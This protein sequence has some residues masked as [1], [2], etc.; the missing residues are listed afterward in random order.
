M[1][2]NA[3]D[4]LQRRP[5][6][7]TILSI[8]M[9][10]SSDGNGHQRYLDSFVSRGCRWR[11]AVRRWTPTGRHPGGRPGR[12]IGTCRGR[13]VANG[14]ILDMC[15]NR[16]ARSCTN[17][18]PP[19]QSHHS[20]CQRSAGDSRE[21]DHLQRPDR[22]NDHLAPPNHHDPATTTTTTSRRPRPRRRPRRP[23][24]ARPRSAGAARRT[25]GPTSGSAVSRVTCGSPTPAPT[26]PRAGT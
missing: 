13:G 4:R 15:V 2:D 7:N 1:R 20:W 12:S 17:R 6:G 23:P 5:D 11:S 14:S 19:G 26:A 18:R 8:P 3:Q 9:Y 21:A 25:P 24:P 22:D 16:A 10:G